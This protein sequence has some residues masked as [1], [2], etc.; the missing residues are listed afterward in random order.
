[1]LV[2]GDAAGEQEKDEEPPKKK[3]GLN[4]FLKFRNEFLRA[5]KLAAGGRK[6][7]ADEVALF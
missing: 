7:S 5:A 6:L 1:M 3:V 2:Q 4:Q